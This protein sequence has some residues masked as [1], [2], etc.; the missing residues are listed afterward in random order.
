M[1]RELVADSFTKI[2]SGPAFEKALQDLCITAGDTKVLSGGGGV[3]QDP[4]N[5]KVAMIVGATLMSGA[6]ATSEEEGEDQLSWFWTIGLILMCVGAV[7]VSDKMVRSGM[8]LYRRLLGTSGSQVDAKIKGQQSTPH[9]NMLHWSSSEEESEGRVAK[10]TKRA[11]YVPAADM[12]ELRAMVSQSRRIQE[13]PH[14]K[15][16]GRTPGMYETESSQLPRRRKKKSE[17][18]QMDSD[19]EAA[20][21]EKARHE[22]IMISLLGNLSGG[23]FSRRRST[24]SGSKQAAASS[25]SNAMISGYGEPHEDVTFLRQSSSRSGSGMVT[26]SK[27]SSSRSGSGVASSCQQSSSRSG[28]GVASSCQQSSSPSGCGVATSSNQRS[29]Q[30]GTGSAVVAAS[31]SESH[32]IESTNPWNQFQHQFSG[33]NWGSEKLRAEYWKYKA[34]GQLPK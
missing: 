34:T 29:S 31:A 9:L 30:S 27:Q 2:V 8:W 1:G 6:A 11:N 22:M 28:S 21:V 17:K 14:N 20:A 7:Y 3:Q 4:I 10:N 19:E 18:K 12:D 23:P 15:I 24:R 5:A 32:G 25:S 16:H 33:R 26:S 13:D